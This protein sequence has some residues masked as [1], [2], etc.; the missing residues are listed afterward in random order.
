MTTQIERGFTVVTFGKPATKLEAHIIKVATA[1]SDGE[2]NQPLDTLEDVYAAL[3]REK[4]LYCTDHPRVKVTSIMIVKSV[5]GPNHQKILI[6][7]SEQL[8]ASA[9]IDFLL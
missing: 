4:Q 3:Q 6:K 7:S 8:V 9:V 2:G 5:H 1:W